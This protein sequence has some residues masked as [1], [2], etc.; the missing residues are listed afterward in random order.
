MTFY[1]KHVSE[2]LRRAGADPTPRNK[3]LL[4]RAIREVLDMDRADA[5]VVWEKVKEIMFSGNDPDRKRD[6][7]EEVVRRMIKYLITG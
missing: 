3:E 1:V 5:P 7:E 6:F 2:L 4:D